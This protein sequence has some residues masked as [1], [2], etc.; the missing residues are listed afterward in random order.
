MQIAII[1][2]VVRLPVQLGRVHTERPGRRSDKRR[3]RH[4]VAA[5]YASDQATRIANLL[6]KA[7]LCEAA[8]FSCSSE[9][10]TD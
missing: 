10:D 1:T 2:H 3:L 4:P 6:G 9:P 8:G 5:L 7:V